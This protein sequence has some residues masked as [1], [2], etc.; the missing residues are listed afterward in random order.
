MCKI[1]RLKNSK[2][3]LAICLVLAAIIIIGIVFWPKAYKFYKHYEHKKYMEK[4]FSVHEDIKPLKPLWTKNGGKEFTY[5]FKIDECDGE[6]TVTAPKGDGN[7]TCIY[8]KDGKEYDASWANLFNSV[9]LEDNNYPDEITGIKSS[10]IDFDGHTDLIITG[11][12]DSKERLWI[13]L[14]QNPYELDD[15]FSDFTGFDEITDTNMLAEERL[16]NLF[17]SNFTVDYIEDWFVGNEKNGELKSYA[18]AYKKVIDFYECTTPGAVSYKLIYFDEDDIPELVATHPWG[19]DC[20]ISMYAFKDG[21]VSEIVDCWPFSAHGQGDFKYKDRGNLLIQ[22][23]EEFNPEGLSKYYYADGII[24]GKM[25]TLYIHKILDKG[26]SVDE[27]K[28]NEK[29][30]KKQQEALKANADK[31][32]YKTSD[33]YSCDEIFQQLNLPGFEVEKISGS[34]STLSFADK[35]FHFEVENRE[36]NK[37]EF[38]LSDGTSSTK[39]KLKCDDYKA[40]LLNRDDDRAYLY[41]VLNIKDDSCLYIY[42]L[43]TRSIHSPIKYDG[44]I[45]TLN[46]KRSHPPIKYDVEY[47]F[48]DDIEN[49]SGFEMVVDVKDLGDYQAK[50]EFYVGVNGMPIEKEEFGYFIKTNPQDG[51]SSNNEFGDTVVLQKDVTFDATKDLSKESIYHSED[52]SDNEVEQVLFKK[53]T[54]F[55]L[56]KYYDDFYSFKDSIR[57]SGNRNYYLVNDDGYMIEIQVDYDDGE[58][59]PN[60]EIVFKPEK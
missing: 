51:A 49:S 31:A 13:R 9:D 60:Q 24:D 57:F 10:D 26:N 4:Y 42:N 37:K 5:K 32:E 30:T 23:F 14:G 46:T 38:F 47:Q 28:F 2:K 53:G 19:G 50:K 20:S 40:F 56:Y 18:D 8:K 43:N 6:Y 12:V 21:R 54:K 41:L 48:R 58:V 15:D 34:S 45:Y 35:E 25:D 17:G 11:T 52:F 7:I 39:Q 59:A 55:Y 36:D 22:L 29:L 27:W 33:G 44:Y 1:I 3:A 16:E